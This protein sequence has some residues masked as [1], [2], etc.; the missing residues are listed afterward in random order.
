MFQR[1][2]S[3]DRLSRL[4]LGD[5]QVVYALQV[6]PELGCCPEEMRESKRSVT[7]YGSPSMQNLSNT[8]GGDIEL[9]RELGSAHA[10]FL[11]LLCQMLT[12][13]NTPVVGRDTRK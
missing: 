8:V 9:P 3:V 13:V 4:L 1:R 11:Q 2:Q 12:R 5:A 10:Q 7:R 6:E